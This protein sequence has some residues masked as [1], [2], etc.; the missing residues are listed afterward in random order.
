MR[1]PQPLKLELKHTSWAESGIRSEAFEE[2]H[3]RSLAAE[4]P[5]KAQQHLRDSRITIA[6]P[7]SL[8]MG[9]RTWRDDMPRKQGEGIAM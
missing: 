1:P 4:A 9:G 2:M 5:A 7:V 8:R 6:Y 3:M